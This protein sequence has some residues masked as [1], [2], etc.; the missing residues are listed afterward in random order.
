MNR[1]T[2]YQKIARAARRG[3]GVRLTFDDVV[4]LSLDDAVRLT[5][6]QDDED[7]DKD[8]PEDPEEG[9]TK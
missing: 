1:R 7:D 2:P 8:A 5:G 4:I 9:E 6:E 3:T